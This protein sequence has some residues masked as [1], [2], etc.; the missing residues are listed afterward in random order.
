MTFLCLLSIVSGVGQHQ[1]YS[2]S[3]LGKSF[4]L[5]TQA[6]ELFQFDNG[7]TVFLFKF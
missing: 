6:T 1:V 3:A 2:L 4:T 5:S 7:N